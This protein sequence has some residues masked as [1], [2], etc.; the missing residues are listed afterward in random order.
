MEIAYNGNKLRELEVEI[1]ELAL[2]YSYTISE[3]SFIDGVH[4]STF[5]LY[6]NPE[7][8]QNFKSDL[9]TLSKRFNTSLLVGG[10]T[11]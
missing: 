6:N 1:L 7:A 11:L 9:K 2:R 3:F 4:A 5:S 10:L 8:L